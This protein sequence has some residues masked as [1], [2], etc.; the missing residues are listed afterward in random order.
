[1]VIRAGNGSLRPITGSA[2][3]GEFCRQAG[4]EPPACWRI[5]RRDAG[6]RRRSGAR[7]T[8]RS[9]CCK[10]VRSSGGPVLG[11]RQEHALGPRSDAF[12]VARRCR[13]KTG[14]C[15]C[16][17]LPAA[18][19]RSGPTAG[20]PRRTN[21]AS[22]QPAQR[23]ASHDS[24]PPGRPAR[25][26]APPRDPRRLLPCGFFARP[27]VEPGAGCRGPAAVRPRKEQ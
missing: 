12:R 10:S 15:R 21:P 6:C 24:G 23:T 1:M 5:F 22:I 9:N 11:R 20:V 26:T 3:K 16:G 8:K 13:P 7:I 17:A 14:A 25:G 2:K 27:A 18:G 4:G 19:R